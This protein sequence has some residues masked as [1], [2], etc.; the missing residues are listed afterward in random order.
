MNKGMTIKQI[1]ELCGID[2]STVYR[3]IQ[4]GTSAEC[5]SALAK[6]KSAREE[7][8][9]AR[10][11]L[12][13]ILAIIRAG[14]K[15]TLADL[16]AENAERRQ[17]IAPALPVNYTE[18]ATAVA[19]AV[20]TAIKP[21]VLELRRPLPTGYRQSTLSLPA[22]TPNGDYYTIKA[23]GSMRGLKITKNIAVTYGREAS[24]LSRERNIEI[25]RV[26]DEEWGEI[27]SYQI[28]VLKEVFTV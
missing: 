12:P 26:P 10:F 7:S 9:S 20:T 16:L 28:S 6:C 18:L 8:I 5:K 23:Y 21:L 17:Q 15:N 27:N 19:A 25:R 13:E 24:K 1:A 3:W 11:T 2:E 4:K 22:S 14:G